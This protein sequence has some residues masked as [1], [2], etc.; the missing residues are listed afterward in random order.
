V[1]SYKAAHNWVKKFPQ[2]SP[3]V[4]YDAQPGRPVEIAT[5]TTVQQV[6]ELIPAVKR[7]TTDGVATAL[8]CPH[9]LAYSIMQDDVKFRKVCAHRVHNQLEII[10]VIR[11]TQATY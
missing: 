2:G 1:F 11:D 4:V 8:G 10:M 9:G 7:I 5:E 3:K 6:E